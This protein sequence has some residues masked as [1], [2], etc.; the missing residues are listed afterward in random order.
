[1][2][3]SIVCML[4]FCGL[5]A[6]A[7]AQS[8]PPGLRACMTEADSLRRLV[9]YDKEMARLT[10]PPPP[11]A[12]MP[13]PP[14]PAPTPASPP[15]AATAA[16]A[17]PATAASTS[18]PTPH[19]SRWKIFTGGSDSRVTAHV[20]SLDRSSNAMVLHLD[21]GQA[22]QQIGRVS[23]DLTLREG[24]SVT[25]EEHLGSYWLSSRYVSDMKVRLAPAA[26]N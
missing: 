8:V 6:G 26:A 14:P 18:P 10:S 9:C 22:W 23:G 3:W 21:N 15:P 7:F 13:P 19:H 4:P 17:P 24:D 1:M 16:P 12:A 11:P 5:S 25:I 20:A 2:T